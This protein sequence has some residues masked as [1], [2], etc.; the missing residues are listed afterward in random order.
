MGI[1][2]QNVLNAVNKDGSARQG[3]RVRV[4]RELS[5]DKGSDAGN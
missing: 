1:G 2:E 3:I 5:W 4:Y